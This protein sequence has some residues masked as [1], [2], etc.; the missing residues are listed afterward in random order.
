MIHMQFLLTFLVNQWYPHPW[1]F[2]AGSLS[3]T[4]IHQKFQYT[5]MS[6]TLQIAN[7]RI[8]DISPILIHLMFQCDGIF[9]M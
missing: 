6:H 4:L 5:R 9:N 3:Q 1:S 8:C 7:V 2:Q